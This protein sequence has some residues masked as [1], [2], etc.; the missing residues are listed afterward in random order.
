LLFEEPTLHVELGVCVLGDEQGGLRCCFPGW[1]G[2]FGCEQFAQAV[3]V[4]DERSAAL[5]S[6]LRR[7]SIRGAGAGSGHELVLLIRLSVIAASSS[8]NW[9]LSALAGSPFSVVRARRL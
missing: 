5:K 2:V 6:D 9:P 3:G 1:P 4:P 8:V 7:V